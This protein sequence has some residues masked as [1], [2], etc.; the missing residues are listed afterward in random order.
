MTE[1]FYILDTNIVL[2]TWG[3]VLAPAGGRLL[4]SRLQDIDHPNNEAGMIDPHSCI[5]S[6]QDISLSVRTPVPRSR[7]VETIRS[8]L[9]KDG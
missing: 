7:T 1:V 4:Y 6:T 8:T 9:G 3:I 5:Q 2:R